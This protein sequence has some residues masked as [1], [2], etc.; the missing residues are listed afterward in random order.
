MPFLYRSSGWLLPLAASLLA[1]AAALLVMRGR[2][3]QAR[4]L[5]G[6]VLLVAVAAYCAS[7][8]SLFAHAGTPALRLAAA[9]VALPVLPLAVGGAM[10]LAAGGLTRRNA[11]GM[12]LGLVPLAAY[13]LTAVAYWLTFGWLA[14]VMTAPQP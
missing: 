5:V 2:R 12:L 11:R 9:T 7:L 13:L 8:W 10:G 3:A 4:A 6:A 1:V 14:P